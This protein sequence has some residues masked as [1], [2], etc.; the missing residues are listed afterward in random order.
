MSNNQN[1][2]SPQKKEWLNADELEIEFGLNKGTQRNMRYKKRIPYS[3]IG[4]IVKYSR[5]KI[6]EW[7]ENHSIEV[8]G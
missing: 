7:L 6:N 8:A 5:A 1:L 4:G 2:P 3:K